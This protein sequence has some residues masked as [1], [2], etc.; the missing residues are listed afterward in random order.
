MISSIKSKIILAVILIVSAGFVAYEAYEF[1]EMKQAATAELHELAD[2]TAVRLAESM[3]LPVWEI[4]KQWVASIIE[5][6]MQDKQLF[7]VIVYADGELFEG[8]ERD[9]RWQST[10]SVNQFDRDYITASRE[11][12]RDGSAIGSVKVYITTRFMSEEIQTRL[13]DEAKVLLLVALLIVITLI[14]LIDRVIVRALQQLLKQTEA[15]ADGDYSQSIQLHQRDEMGRLAASIDRMKGSIQQREAERNQ[16]LDSVRESER[17]YR[18]S[19]DNAAD[20]F[21]MIDMNGYFKDVNQMACSS[22][23]YRRDELLTMSLADMETSF[24]LDQLSALFSSMQI[25]EMK[26]LEGDHLRKDGSTFPVEVRISLNELDGERYILAFARDVSERKQAE[27]ILRESETRFKGLAQQVPVPLCYVAKSGDVEFMNSRFTSTFGYTLEDMPTIE[28]WWPLAYPDESYREWVLETWGEACQRAIENQH[29][30]EPI[31]YRVR[32]KSGDVKTVEISGV[33]LGE[34]L[35]ATLVDMTERIE[36]EA[37]IRK[38]SLAVE[39]SGEAIMITDLQG[40]IEYINPAFSEMTGYTENEALGQKPNLLK[41]G[42]QSEAY[43]KSM[44][45]RLADGKVWHGKVVNRKKSGDFYPAMLTISPIKNQQGETTNYIALQQSLE[46]MEALEAQFHQSQKMEAIG[47]LVGGIAH[48]FNNNLA[49][50]TGNLYLAKKAA[51]D[52]PEIGQRLEN[53]EKLAFGAA[54]TIQQL[55]AF[56]RKG[57]VQMHPLSIASFLKETVKLSEISL[58]ENIAFKLNVNDPDMKINGDITQ[59][60][61]VLM[62]LINNAHDAVDDCSEPCIAISLH[63]F[64]ADKQFIAMHEG[65]REGEYAC[66]EVRDNGCGMSEENIQH[67]FE[68]F[69]TT[70]ELGK[71]TGLGLAMVYGAVK[72]HGGVI[73]VQSAQGETS[74]T[75]MQIYLPLIESDALLTGDVDMDQV[76]S[77]QGETILL[78]DDNQTV[79][80]TGRDV[81][82]GLGY[83]V[84]TAEDGESAIEVYKTHMSEIDLIILDVVMPKLGGVEALQAIK[85]FNPEVKAMFATGYDKASTLGGMNQELKERVISKPFAMSKLSQMIREVLES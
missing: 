70:K 38:L 49:G 14:T 79:L 59:L 62:N 60:Q 58:P 63:R 41:S 73:D 1:T 16:A 43:Y 54:A 78:V 22:L 39:Q 44:W 69:F 71:G 12:M 6:D 24:S 36:S 61:Q 11:I 9:N 17:R 77:G 67:I 33:F 34:D 46:E 13:I 80:E 51:K 19:I 15:I 65:L 2:R 20:A 7:A 3:V 50:I 8:R 68:P 30:I 26:S 18:A 84:L 56:S 10:P 48:D 29:D 40:T 21:F 37:N 32:C 76:V 81:L 35:L 82:E 31:E 66:I 72:T 42:N 25:G 53:V 75:T 83:Q 52:I 64:H 28:Q 4:D 27:N 23:G 55:L 74:G 47:T 5:S 45:D 57:V 85:D